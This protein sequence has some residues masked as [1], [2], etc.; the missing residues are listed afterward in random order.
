MLALKRSLAVK[1]KASWAFS[2]SRVSTRATTSA[3]APGLCPLAVL[4]YQSTIIAPNVRSPA[5]AGAE[6]PLLQ[7]LRPVSVRSKSSYKKQI[8][9]GWFSALAGGFRPRGSET[10]SSSSVIQTCVWIFLRFTHSEPGRAGQRLSSLGPRNL[11]QMLLLTYVGPFAA[12]Y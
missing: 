4:N 10:T 12:R 7:I 2:M 9:A 11:Q 6:R 8:K 3:L 1:A 5:V